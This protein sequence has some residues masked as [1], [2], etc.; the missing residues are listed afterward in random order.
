VKARN[1]ARTFVHSPAD[2]QRISTGRRAIGLATRLN[3]GSIRL[4][5][6]T[7]PIRG[8][9]RFQTNDRSN[10]RL[11][12]YWRCSAFEI[13]AAPEKRRSPAS[14]PTVPSSF[15]SPSAYPRQT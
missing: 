9:L 13:A 12:R 4:R 14:L 1:S 3:S 7:P 5:E 6:L 11:S 8:N 15:R 2:Q 10:A